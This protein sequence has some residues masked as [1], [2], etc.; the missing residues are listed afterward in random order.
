MSFSIVKKTVPEIINE[1]I[2]TKLLNDCNN[3]DNNIINKLFISINS[4]ED[5]RLLEK[6]LNPKEFPEPIL[7]FS[8]NAHNNFNEFYND[9]NIFLN[10]NDNNEIFSN[11][12]LLFECIKNIIENDV[13]NIDNNIIVYLQ[14]FF[15]KYDN[16]NENIYSSYLYY[17]KELS[18]INNNL[19]SINKLNSIKE[20]EINLNNKNDISQYLINP[21]FFLHYIEFTIYFFIKKNYYNDNTKINTI[22]EQYNFILNLIIIFTINNNNP[23][24]NKKIFI[25]N[26]I[27]TTYLKFLISNLIYLIINNKKYVNKETLELTYFNLLKISFEYNLPKNVNSNEIYL[28]SLLS[29]LIIIINNMNE[30]FIIENFNKIS[31]NFKEQIFSQNFDNLDEIK[32]ILII[33]K[34][35]DFYLMKKFEKKIDNIKTKLNFLNFD[36]YI[37]L[38]AFLYD[39]SLDYIKYHIKNFKEKFYWNFTEILNLVFIKKFSFPKFFKKILYRYLI[40]IPDNKSLL[41]NLMNYFYNNKNFK[42]T[43]ILALKIL[44]NI[45][46]D[47]D[48]NNINSIENNNNQNENIILF[49]IETITLFI[50]SNIYINEEKYSDAKNLSILNLE[51]ILNYHNNNNYFNNNNNNNNNNN[52]NI[53]N[54]LSKVYLNLGN[55]YKKLGNFTPNENEKQNNFNKAK[56]Y[57]ENAYKCN[58][59]SNLKYHLMSQLYML[60]NYNE[61]DNYFNDNNNNN[62]N[63]KNQNEIKNTTLNIVNL[64][65]LLKYEDAYKICKDKLKFLIKN[66]NILNF[67]KIYILYFYLNFIKII[68]TNNT[69]NENENKIKDN[70]K[71]N[72]SDLEKL[73]NDLFK[74]FND[75]IKEISNVKKQ[76]ENFSNENKF[77]DKIESYKKLIDSLFND[78]KINYFNSSKSKKNYNS[79]KIENL[80]IEI[81]KNIFLLLYLFKN[82]FHENENNI[83]I[84]QMNEII[85]TVEINNNDDDNN[86]LLIFSIKNYFEK[87]FLNS[88]NNL[89]KILENKKNDLIAIKILIDILINNKNYSDAFIYT[90]KGIKI[91]N[92]EEGFYYYLSKYYYF[93]NDLN[94]FYECSMKE[95]ENSK[96]KN[97]QF[98]RDLIDS[99]TIY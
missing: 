10:N 6:K 64:I 80:K 86:I 48:I 21:L 17:L 82:N 73:I 59:S 18:L 24:N 88:E 11:Q 97:L 29:I 92:Q 27:F 35:I 39:N 36:D 75:L 76:I 69:F 22:L 20:S 31:L 1:Q 96:Y 55:C 42:K 50:L 12:I 68:Q 70:N 38:N 26:D 7:N 40:H 77:D 23:N 66:N 87:N 91:D 41:Y 61:L 85:K 84:N 28:F 14:N 56:E 63:N 67:Y 47:I 2:L 95:I 93:Y 79:I 65:S 4:N 45:N 94:K 44:S 15:N 30:K 9:L 99:E 71:I 54:F 72:N 3:I 58:N 60:K 53:K 98:L 51:R 32:I 8:K 46:F 25:L 83:I 5:P 43:K 74:I 62:I 13:N 19:S 78:E 81:V 37:L 90:M 57:Y 16:N 89:R 49:E 52:E 34:A 33:I